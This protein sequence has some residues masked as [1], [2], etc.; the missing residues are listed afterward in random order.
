MSKIDDVLRFLLDGTWHDLPEI[1]QA[2]HIGD[3]KLEKIVQLLTEFG[4]IQSNNLKVRITLDTRK[5]FESL[6]HDPEREQRKD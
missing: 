3:Q 5:F 6:S 4:F 1:T 2:T